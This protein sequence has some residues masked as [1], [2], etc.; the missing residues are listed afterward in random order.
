ME[1]E[2]TGRMMQPE[3]EARIRQAL[4]GEQPGNHIG[5]SNIASRLRLI[6]RGEASITVERVEDRTRVR[7]EIPFGEKEES[8]G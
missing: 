2:N 8:R 5:L 3:D 1:I 6:Y 4:A 7:M